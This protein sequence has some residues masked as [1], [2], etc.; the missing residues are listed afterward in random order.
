M[1]NGIVY[2]Q[3]ILQPHIFDNQFNRSIAIFYAHSHF[4]F[5]FIV[6]LHLL[7][8]K[9]WNTITSIVELLIKD[10]ILKWHTDFIQ[11]ILACE[12]CESF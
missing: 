5:F 6:I 10:Y 1:I 7:I 3:W 12:K 8:W 4:H 11:K 9:N 2:V